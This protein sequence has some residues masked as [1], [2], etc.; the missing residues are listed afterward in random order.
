[1]LNSIFGLLLALG[2]LVTIHEFGHFWVA[3]RCGVKVLRFS[4]GFGKPIWSKK[5]RTGTEFA[6]G[7]IPLGGYVKMLDE[8]EGAV[9]ESERAYSFNSKPPWQK[10]LIA[11]AGP[12]ANIVFAIFA[13][14]LM[15]MIGIQDLATLVDRP[16]AGTPL[17]QAGLQRGDLVLKVD[18]EDVKSFSE[19]ALTLAGRVGDTGRI[20]FV[21]SHDGVLRTVNVEIEDWL[22]SSKTPDP[23]GNLGLIP[24]IPTV[25]ATI[26]R[27]EPQGAADA[28]GLQPSDVVTAV[29]GN[30]IDSWGQWVDVIRANAGN[31]LRLSIKRDNQLMQV[32]ITPAVKAQDDGSVIGYVGA[33]SAG[34]AWPDEQMV[35]SR[36]TPWMAAVKG[37]NQTWDMVGLSYQMLWKMITGKVS[38][39]QIGGPISMAQMAGTSVSSGFEAFI[40]FLAF[41][42]ISLAIVNLLPVPV[43]DGGH[44][45]MHSIEWIIRKPLSERVQMV[46]MQ[47]GIAFVLTLMCLAFFNDIGRF[48]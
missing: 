27:I 32:N 47:I 34:F 25:P 42:S 40:G 45:A 20:A 8:R 24:Q 5:D 41:I 30:P 6:L 44:V 14:A 38:V 36:F 13:F 21:V 7:P 12:I 39:R 29:D 3:R 46:G 26:G 17:Y 22:S 10:I 18:G 15:Y 37:W 9:P 1:L 19:M 4:I 23:L 43:L 16:D 33:G 11:L 31:T 48:F 35:T 28:A 2:I